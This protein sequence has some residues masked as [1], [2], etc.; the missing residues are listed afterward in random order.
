MLGR[1]IP[2]GGGLVSGMCGRGCGEGGTETTYP[3]CSNEPDDGEDGAELEVDD[4]AA[5]DA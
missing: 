1:R 5:G 2:G 4:V 3:Q